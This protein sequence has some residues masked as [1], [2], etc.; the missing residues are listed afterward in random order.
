MRLPYNAPLALP[1]RNS[2][3]DIAP[4]EVCKSSESITECKP[5]ITGRLFFL[6]H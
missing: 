3:E 5:Y 2:S 4:H 1:V 6:K